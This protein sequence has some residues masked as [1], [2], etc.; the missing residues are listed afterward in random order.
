MK[1]TEYRSRVDYPEKCQ[2]LWNEIRNAREEGRE[3]IYLDE[4]NFTKLSLPTR[5]WSTKYT[6]LNVEQEDVYQGYRSVLVSMHETNGIENPKIQDHAINSQDFISYLKMMRSRHHKKPLA[7]LMDQL[8]VHKSWAV[9]PYYDALDIKPIFNV[10][11]SPEFNPIESVFS[12][13]KRH[14]K[15]SRLYY[16]V[17]QKGFD[18][19]KTIRH[20]FWK[21]TAH[22]CRACVKKS[23][24]L[25]E[26][27][28]IVNN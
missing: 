24:R 14:F 7:L 6:N 19:E 9:K 5:E 22:N 2:K 10:G 20:S 3:L 18:F 27:A 21:V 15:C 23:E 8:N 12:K 25:L 16:I 11:Y 4:T 17:N 26:K 1:S 28:L 13:V